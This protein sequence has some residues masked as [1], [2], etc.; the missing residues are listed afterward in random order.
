M[1]IDDRSNSYGGINVATRNT[2]KDLNADHHYQSKDQANV[3]VRGGH[4]Q[5]TNAS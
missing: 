4:T 2:A 3:Q 5:G 1:V